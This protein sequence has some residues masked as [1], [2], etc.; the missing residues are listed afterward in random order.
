MFLFGY[1]KVTNSDFFSLKKTRFVYLSVC[2][3]K[4]KKKFQL[5]KN[6]NLNKEMSKDYCKSV[7]FSSFN[8]YTKDKYFQIIYHTL[9]TL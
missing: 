5:K 8:K 1:Q 6:R 3:L 4:N 9:Q 7:H 2:T